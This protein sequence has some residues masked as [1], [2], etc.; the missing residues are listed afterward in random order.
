MKP[1]RKVIIIIII[2]IIDHFVICHKSNYYSEAWDVKVT[3]SESLAYWKKIYVFN[4][5]F[6]DSNF[7]AAPMSQN[8]CIQWQT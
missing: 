2:I 8:M 6:K 1:G 7:S 4:A 3:A 5:I